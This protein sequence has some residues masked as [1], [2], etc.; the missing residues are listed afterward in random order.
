LIPVVAHALCVTRHHFV[1][2]HDMADEFYCGTLVEARKHLQV[3]LGHR[4]HG[5]SGPAPGAQSTR[6]DV[7]IESFFTQDMRHTGAG[8]FA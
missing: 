1:V 5:I 3:F 2:M 8:G 4:F 7:R 6:H